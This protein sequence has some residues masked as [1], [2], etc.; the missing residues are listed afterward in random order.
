MKWK[1]WLKCGTH[2]IWNFSVQISRWVRHI[3]KHCIFVCIVKVKDVSYVASCHM[4][5][6][7]PVVQMNV[8][9]RQSCQYRSGNPYF[10]YY[11]DVVIQACFLLEEVNDFPKK[12]NFIIVK[13]W[14]Y[15]YFIGFRFS[16][17]WY[18]L[19]CFPAEIC[20]R[21]TVDN[22]YSSA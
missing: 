16:L 11:M 12:Y 20:F 6:N 3:A 2:V 15:I 21:R 10:L 18:S 22:R 14:I 8:T 5:V 13:Q 7:A 19:I 1:K 4:A 9:I 17:I